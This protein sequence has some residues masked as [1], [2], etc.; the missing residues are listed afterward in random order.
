M[1]QEELSFQ[2]AIYAKLR[3]ILTAEPARG[4]T[5]WLHDLLPRRN[6]QPVG[7]TPSRAI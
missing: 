3:V 6:I 4:K 7:F 5:I 1:A 2:F